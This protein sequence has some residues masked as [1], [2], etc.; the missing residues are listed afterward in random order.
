M[1]TWHILLIILVILVAAL[2]ALYFHGKKCKVISLFILMNVM[3]ASTSAR[4]VI[5]TAYIA[6]APIMP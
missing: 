6:T 1:Q 3:T 4:P 2:V 5:S